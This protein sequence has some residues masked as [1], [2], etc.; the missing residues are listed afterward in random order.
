MTIQAHPE[1][2]ENYEVTLL[3]L[4]AGNIVPRPAAEKALRWIDKSG[5]KAD[6]QL[7]AE[8]IVAFLKMM[9]RRQETG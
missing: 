6:T 4:Y 2:E 5:E 7:L 1:F 8:W 3:N 9:T